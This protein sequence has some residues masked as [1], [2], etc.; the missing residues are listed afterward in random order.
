MSEIWKQIEGFPGYSVSSHGRVCGIKGILKPHVSGGKPY[1]TVGLYRNRKRH[2]FTVHRLVMDA[3]I[4]CLP[5]GFDRSHIDGNPQNNRLENLIFEKKSDNN[6]RKVEH[7]TIQR[8]EKSTGARLSSKQVS[9]IRADARKST[10][11]A[12]A[13]NCSKSTINRIRANSIWTDTPRAQ[14]GAA[15]TA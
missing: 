11:L 9:L 6:Q 1:L 8:G 7:G 5:E 12:R 3:F 15:R 13:F 4:G 10:E 2:P 14:N